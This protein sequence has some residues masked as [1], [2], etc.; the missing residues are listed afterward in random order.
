MDEAKSTRYKMSLW[1]KVWGRKV[2]LIDEPIPLIGHIAFG[3][4]DRGT[5]VLQVRPTTLC[6]LSCI[7]CSVDAGPQS[8]WRQ[9]EYIVNYKWLAHWV[10]MTAREKGITVEALIDGVGDPLTYPWLVKLI[11]EI[12]KRGVAHSI[13][14]ETHA[15]TLTRQLVHKLEEAGLDR[16]NLSIETLKPDKAKMLTAT[17]WYN[18]KRVVEIAEYIAKETSIDLHV[19]PVWLPGINDDD[20][21]ELVEWAYRIGAGK[22]WPPVTIQ[23]YVKHKYGRHPKDVRE[24]SWNEYW[25]WIKTLEKRLSKRIT[26]SMEDWGMRR[27]KRIKKRLRRGEAARALILGP[28]WLK[29]ERLAVVPSAKRVVTV[30]GYAKEVDGEVFVRI[31]R[32]KDEIYIARYLHNAR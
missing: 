1:A 16:I 19:T 12:K 13:A 10:E 26:W 20:I 22:K 3:V 6:N 31:T 18:L 24:V 4:I 17:K 30:V 28:G 21:P 5:N 7:F 14:L 32:D 11:E 2:Y 23:K 9:A 29:R 25:S 15:A 8:R 27:A